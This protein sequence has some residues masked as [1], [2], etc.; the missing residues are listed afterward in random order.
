MPSKIVAALEIGSETTKVLVGD[1][2]D[3]E[4]LNI[5]GKSEVD[6][7][8]VSK[9]IVRDYNKV[10][11]RVGEA[12]EQAEATAGTQIDSVYLAVAGSHLEGISHPARLRVRSQDN[13]VTEE[14]VQR[15]QEEAKS[16]EL[17]T[18]RLYI[19]FIRNHYTLDGKSVREPVGMQGEELGVTYWLL[20]GD[21]RTVADLIHA[22]NSHNIHVEDV[23]VSS[24]ASS[25]MVA[26]DEE[27]SAGCLVIDIGKGTT[28]YAFYRSGFIVRTGSVPVGGEHFTNDLSVGLRVNN[29][30]AEHLKR[31]NASAI[32]DTDDS[33]RTVQLYG[34]W[35]IG[36]KTF[37]LSSINRILEVRIEE[38]FEII[39]EE[40]GA[41]RIKE[42]AVSVL[43]TGGGSRTRKISLAAEKIFGI[44][45]RTTRNPE[46]VADELRDPEYSTVLGVLHYALEAE[47][48][49]K[50]VR[51]RKS[52]KGITSHLTR[53]LGGNRS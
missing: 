48:S 43:L 31:E 50:L 36:D 33:V 12:L 32:V 38:L 44:P 20:H 7:E 2:I 6:S 30:S 37:Y 42:G 15:V 39:R 23:I 19:H 40:C 47:E 25:C 10:T 16:K 8:G 46:W 29:K 45:A 14:D 41:T 27:K 17:P 1:I 4:S 22:V 52:A 35:M 9:G 49:Q 13:R 11:Q 51:K 21:S 18:D 5:I 3:F 26:S 28:D 53:L 34:D 24:V